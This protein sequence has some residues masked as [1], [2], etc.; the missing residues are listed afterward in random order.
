MSDPFP[1][2]I[3]ALFVLF[4]FTFVVALIAQPATSP[5]GQGMAGS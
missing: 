1:K 3:S 2:S 5:H 4:L